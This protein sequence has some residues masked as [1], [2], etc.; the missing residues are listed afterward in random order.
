MD[1][2]T[3]GL[4]DEDLLRDKARDDLASISVPVPGAG[5]VSFVSLPPAEQMRWLIDRREI[6]ERV[7]RFD[8]ESHLTAWFSEREWRWVSGMLGR[9]GDAPRIATEWE[10]VG[11][12]DTP[13]E[14]FNGLR[15]TGAEITARGVTVIFLGPKEADG[16]E[17]LRFQR[18]V[19]WAGLFAQLGLTL[20]W[21]VPVADG[22]REG[23]GG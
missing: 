11:T 8:V 10:Y 16:P 21:R 13:D 7:V 2:A 15:P 14:S 4:P 22:L 9:E 17:V 3:Q 18:Y 6:A 23:A 12:H 5:D 19:D 1:S 20:N